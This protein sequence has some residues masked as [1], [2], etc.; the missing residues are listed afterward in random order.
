MKVLQERAINNFPKNEMMRTVPLI[1]TE[2]DILYR[3]LS[4]SK[5]FELWQ[6]GKWQLCGCSVL[7]VESAFNHKSQET[8][9]EEALKRGD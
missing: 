8:V 6:S 4:M 3:A 9:C 7:D 5:Y 2:K 1:P